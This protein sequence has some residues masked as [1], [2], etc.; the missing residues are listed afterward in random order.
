MDAVFQ[1]TRE[2]GQALIESEAFQ[3]MK[4]A[5][6]KAAENREAA[7]MMQKYID[8]RTQIQELLSQENPDSAVLK[9]LSDEMDQTQSALNAMEDI[10]AMNEARAAFSE[11]INQVHQVL[12]FIVPG[13]MPEE[14]GGCGGSCS[15]CAGCHTTH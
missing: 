10:V 7:E 15:S 8:A 9:R 5:E 14:N 13:R 6:E 4:A 12:Q 11:L 2:L 1:K 3:A